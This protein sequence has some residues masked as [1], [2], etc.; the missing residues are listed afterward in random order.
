MV[1]SVD[2]LLEKYGGETVIR[3]LRPFLTERRRE[4]IE[5]VLS[6]RLASLTVAIEN[7]HDPH[8]GAAAIRSLEGFGL[9]QLHVVE[10]TEPFVCSSAV[11]ISAEKW[12]S[13]RRHADFDTCAADLR[14]QGFQLLA[15][16]PRLGHERAVMIEE[17]D[18]SRPL[19]CIFGNER[20]GLAAES[21]AA[22]DVEVTLPMHGF[23][24]SFNL[25]V[26]VALVVQE[27]SRRRRLEIGAEGDLSGEE[28]ARLRARWYALS[29]QHAEAIL[30]QS[31]SGLTHEN[32]GEFPHEEEE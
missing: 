17:V 11:T 23:T 8:N 21:V 2:C 5:E 16:V 6:A 10:A 22:C 27:L 14:E 7:L 13:M 4:R 25:S 15:M 32:V 20:D 9:Q 29:V 19:A 1:D 30:K 24:Q 18:V 28:R 26:S 3:A 31:V 12:I